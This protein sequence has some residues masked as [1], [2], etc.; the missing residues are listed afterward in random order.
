MPE[1]TDVGIGFDGMTLMG[2]WR[3]ARSLMD[4][5]KYHVNNMYWESDY[6]TE[7]YGFR[8]CTCYR[9]CI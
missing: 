4:L 1:E 9:H 5:R 2:S 3:H 7:R 8:F 6:S